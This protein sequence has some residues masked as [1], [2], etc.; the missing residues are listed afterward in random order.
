MLFPGL[1]PPDTRPRLAYMKTLLPSKLSF[2]LFSP[3]LMPFGQ[4]NPMGRG[5]EEGKKRI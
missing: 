1:M 3:P 5:R 2:P 4:E